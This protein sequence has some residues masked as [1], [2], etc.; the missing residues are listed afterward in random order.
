MRNK[1][2]RSSK[3]DSRR[4][5]TVFHRKMSLASASWIMRRI[6]CM[7]FAFPVSLFEA[8]RMFGLSRETFS[9]LRCRWILLCELSAHHK[10]RRGSE[11]NAFRINEKIDSQWWSHGFARLSLFSMSLRYRKLGATCYASKDRGCWILFSS[12]SK[13][14]EKNLRLQCRFLE[15]QKY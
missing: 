12:V 15:L 11:Q 14:P 1:T 13:F 10:P 6:S 7:L 4:L 3:F 2:A 5:P 9:G 8:S